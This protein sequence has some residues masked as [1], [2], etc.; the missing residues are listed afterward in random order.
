MRRTHAL[1]RAP[2]SPRPS[3]AHT[4]RFEGGRLDINPTHSFPV[5]RPTAE[6]LLTRTAA[7]R[8]RAG[9]LRRPP[10]R[11]RDWPADARTR[12]QR[13][14]FRPQNDPHIPTKSNQQQA[15]EGALMKKGGTTIRIRVCDDDR[16][17]RKKKNSIRPTQARSRSVGLVDVNQTSV[18]F[19]RPAPARGRVG[20][21][22]DRSIGSSC[23]VDLSVVGRT[24]SSI[25]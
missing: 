13:A 20:R 22:L 4:R 10:P 3:R 2:S 17:L 18:G 5:L 15:S 7:G 9:P 19:G 1:C 24:R 6:P 12:P 25:G 14:R 11:I 8:A 21:M 16:V 23:S